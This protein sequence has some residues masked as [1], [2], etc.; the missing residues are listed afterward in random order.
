MKQLYYSLYVG[1]II[2]AVLFNFACRGRLSSRTRAFGNLAWGVVC[3]VFMLL[4]SEPQ[5]WFHEFRIGYWRAGNLVLSSPKEM[6]G[7]LQLSYVNLP[8]LALAFLP[9]ASLGAYFAGAIFASLGVAAAILAYFQLVRMARL[10]RRGRWLLAGL[11][12]INGPLFYCLRQGNATVFVLP[13]LLAALCALEIG[14]E[15]KCGVLLGAI[16]LLKPPLLLLPGYYVLRRRWPVVVAA[17]A[18]VLGTTVASLLVFGVDVHRAWYDCCV[19]PFQ[20]RALSSY[21]SQSLSSF[22]VRWTTEGDCGEVWWPVAVGARF[23]ALHHGSV[24]FLAVVTLALC[25]SRAGHKRDVAN[26]LDFC[27]VLCLA[28]IASPVCWTHYF[29]LLLL[30]GALLLSNSVGPRSVGRLAALAFA[31]A[32]LSPPVRGWAVDRWWLAIL[33]SHYLIGAVTLMATLA[34]ARRGLAREYAQSHL[35]MASL[36]RVA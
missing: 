25:L 36:R 26:R 3:V 5:D 32:V 7:A 24:A 34:V 8:I 21:T 31:F 9:F 12:V 22:L 29:L 14:H 19:R 13:M 27:L 11:F 6:Y 28:L 15:R 16:A 35:P 4:A 23:E 20:G 18:V 10:G 2:V 1:W 33:V 30:P 17:A